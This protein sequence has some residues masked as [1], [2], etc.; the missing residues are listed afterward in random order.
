MLDRAQVHSIC[1]K[2]TGKE[3]VTEEDGTET[4]GIDIDEEFEPFF[5]QM[6][7]AEEELEPIGFDDAKECVLLYAIS[8]QIIP[9]RL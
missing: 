6:P 5:A 4:G 7:K 2:A 8:V 1:E 3:K 9:T